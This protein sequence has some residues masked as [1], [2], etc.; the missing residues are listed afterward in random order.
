MGLQSMHTYQT[1][2]IYELEPGGDPSK[3]PS[4]VSICEVT[5]PPNSEKAQF[6]SRR[7]RVIFNDLLSEDLSAFGF[8]RY[9]GAYWEGT[10]LGRPSVIYHRNAAG[11]P[12]FQLEIA[13]RFLS[14][15]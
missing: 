13:E 6:L 8:F 12:Q 5:G 14:G 3:I 7:A 10:I 2:I 9:G 11:I 15:N 1:Q 4:F